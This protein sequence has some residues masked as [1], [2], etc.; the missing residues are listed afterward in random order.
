M[1]AGAPASGAARM[2]RWRPLGGGSSLVLRCAALPQGVEGAR[3]AQE[4]PARVGGGGEGDLGLPA[5][6]GENSRSLESLKGGEVKGVVV[7]IAK[8]LSF[9]IGCPRSRHGSNQPL[10]RSLALVWRGSSCQPV[11]VLCLHLVTLYAR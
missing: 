5:P 10:P 7:R 2:V 3:G 4:L 6:L 11:Q 8:G 9:L 1:A